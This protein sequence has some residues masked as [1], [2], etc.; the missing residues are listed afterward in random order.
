HVTVVQTCALPISSRGINRWLNRH[1]AVLFFPLLTLAGLDL[2]RASLQGLLGANGA[3]VRRRGLELALLAAHAAGY[4]GALFTVLPP[5]LALAFLAVHQGLFGVYLGSIFAPNHKGMPMPTERMDF[6]RKQVLTS[7]NV[8]GGRL[9]DGLVHVV[10]GGLNHQIEHHL[11]PSMPTPNLRRARP[12]V[13]GF[14]AEIGV[15]YHE[16]GLERSSAESLRQLKEASAPLPTGPA[17]PAAGGRD[18]RARVLRRDRG[19]LHR[20]GAG[21]V[22]GGVAAAAEGGER[23]AAVLTAGAGRGRP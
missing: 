22:V 5:G 6:L 10:M 7:R 20:D 19:A 8:A 4:L 2:R 14:C 23:P 16:T 18:A 1:Q 21:A 11:F 3:R 13:R 17:E 9:T 12:I 15:P